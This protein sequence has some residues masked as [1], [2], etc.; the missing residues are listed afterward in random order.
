MPIT[1][2][3]P[4]PRGRPPRLETMPKMYLI[5]CFEPNGYRPHIYNPTPCLT[6]TLPEAKRAVRHLIKKGITA[7][8]EV[9]YVGH[10]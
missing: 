8:F 1:K 10:W 4:Y 3:L 2:K 9:V 7:W 6:E 5:F